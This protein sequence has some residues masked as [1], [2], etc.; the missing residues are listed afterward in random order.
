M[1]L[2]DNIFKRHKDREYDRLYDSEEIKLDDSYEDVYDEE[3]NEVN[4]DYCYTEM[5]WKDGQYICPGC[6]QVMSRKVFFNYIGANPP[7]PECEQCDN[8]YPGCIACPHGY[9]DADI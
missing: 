1:G 5:K 6:G 8:I 9:V 4:C 3:G 7:G 2:F